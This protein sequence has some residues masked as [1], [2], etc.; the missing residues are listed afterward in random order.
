MRQFVENKAVED[1]KER[2]IECWYEMFGR[3]PVF[4]KLD[5]EA[6]AWVIRQIDRDECLDAIKHYFTMK[7]EW[8][9]RNGFSVGVFKDKINLILADMTKASE[10][11]SNSKKKRMS[12]ID[13]IMENAKCSKREARI[14]L[15]L[16]PDGLDDWMVTPPYELSDRHFEEWKKLKGWDLEKA[17]K[18]VKDVAEN[19]GSKL[20]DDSICRQREAPRVDMEGF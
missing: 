20:Q 13:L 14:R 2:Y 5:F 18:T 6:L 19:L 7:D 9:I 8:F 17:K 1:A 3:S 4:G 10:R 16:D 11:R 12:E 15:N